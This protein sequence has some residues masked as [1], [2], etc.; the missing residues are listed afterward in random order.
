[1]RRLSWQSPTARSLPDRWPNTPSPP[2]SCEQPKDPPRSRKPPVHP[3]A[4]L[5]VTATD[6]R[7]WV[8][9][10]PAGPDIGC[11]A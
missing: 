1:V 9:G 2:T 7:V 4:A 10:R 6:V 3:N 11:A 5:R 8:T